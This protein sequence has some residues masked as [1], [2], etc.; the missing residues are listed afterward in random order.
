LWHKTENHKGGVT[1]AGTLFMQVRHLAAS[2][3]PANIKLE[4]NVIF[5][6][7]NWEILHCEVLAISSFA[8]GL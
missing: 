1:S 7:F 3:K 2:N 6:S 4:K 8:L 5:V